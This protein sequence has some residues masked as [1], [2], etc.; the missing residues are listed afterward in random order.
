MLESIH[1]TPFIQGGGLVGQEWFNICLGETKISRSGNEALRE[2]MN[3][4]LNFSNI[5]LSG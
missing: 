2:G 1:S 3:V 4:R 5:E